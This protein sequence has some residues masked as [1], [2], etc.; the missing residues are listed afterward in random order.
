M[1]RSR[2]FGWQ[3]MKA[4]GMLA[5]AP[6][7]GIFCHLRDSCRVLSVV[8]LPAPRISELGQ[9]SSSSWE[10]PAESHEK[11]QAALNG[12]EEAREVVK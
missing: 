7:E 10:K 8:F 5:Q 9:G 4:E 12:T 3:E 6:G 2:S 11:A 1:T